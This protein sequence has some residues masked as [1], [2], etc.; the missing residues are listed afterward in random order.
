MHSIVTQTE[1]GRFEWT[2]QSPASEACTRFAF[3]VALLLLG[4][5]DASAQHYPDIAKLHNAYYRKNQNL[6]SEDPAQT[7]ADHALARLPDHGNASCTK[8][9]CVIHMFHRSGCK[10]FKWSKDFDDRYVTIKKKNQTLDTHAL[11]QFVSRVFGT[12]IRAAQKEAPVR[13]AQTIQQLAPATF[14]RLLAESVRNATSGVHL[15]Y[16]APEVLHTEEFK[17]YLAAVDAVIEAD[18]VPVRRIVHI[19]DVGKLRWIRDCITKYEL[20]HNFRVK[21]VAGEIDLASLKHPIPLNVQ[22]IDSQQV[23][24]VDPRTG[25]HTLDSLRA[26]SFLITHPEFAE[27]ML[28]YYERFWE[29]CIPLKNA[30]GVDHEKLRDFENRFPEV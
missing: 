21:A 26:R 17:A 13:R 27:G 29:M 8:L 20:R 18:K 30:K 2:V 6:A 3:V 7:W 14:Y 28:E 24:V 1:S 25:F 11:E 23:F 16:F 19:N 4:H 12:P 22:I 10:C 15:T 5:K 9:A